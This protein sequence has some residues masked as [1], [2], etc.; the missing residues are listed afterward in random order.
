MGRNTHRPN[1]EKAQQ[2]GCV[3]SGC[4]GSLHGQRGWREIAVQPPQVRADMRR[5]L[6]NSLQT[7]KRSGTLRANAGNRL[8][9]LNLARLDIADRLW[10]DAD[11]MPARPA[12]LRDVTRDSAEFAYVSALADHLME[13]TWHEMSAAIDGAFPDPG[14]ATAVK[15]RMAS[16]VWCSVLVTLIHAMEVAELLA[17]RTREL[18]RDVVRQHFPPE[19][20]AMVADIVVG[21]LWAALTGLLQAHFPLVGAKPL[22]ALRILTVFACPSVD[23]H[24]EVYRHAMQPLMREGHEVIS[25]RVKTWISGVFGAWWNRQGLAPAA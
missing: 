2:P 3:C 16:H 20:A 11:G 6:E 18:L 7:D 8:A 4:G 21:R 19:I 9:C 15:K 25:D 24:P 1:C 5:G 10:R 22:R 14:T 23:R 17:A 13:Q 12:A